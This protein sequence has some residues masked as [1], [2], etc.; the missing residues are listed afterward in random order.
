MNVQLIATIKAVGIF[1]KAIITFM[2]E[3][4]LW[5]YLE[6]LVDVSEKKIIKE[7]EQQEDPK[8]D[9]KNFKQIL[10]KQKQ[11]LS[12]IE[13]YSFILANLQSHAPSEAFLLHF[14]KVCSI[15]VRHHRKLYPKY[16]NRLYEALAH[17]TM[18][19]AHHKTAFIQWS[20]KFVRSSLTETLKIPDSVIFGGESPLESL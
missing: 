9:F 11:L 5:N 17:F 2:G 16:R 10:K 18:S 12:F 20:K 14:F 6:K 8:N 15:G 3:D 7:F 1:S 13:S 4:E 19:L